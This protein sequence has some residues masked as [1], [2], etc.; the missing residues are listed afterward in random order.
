MGR[1]ENNKRTKLRGKKL[2][3]FLS[4]ERKRK[5]MTQ[6]ELAKL[7]GLSLDTIRS[8]ENKR[9]ASPSFFIIVDISKVL[10]INFN[11]IQKM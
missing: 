4:K 5:N 11:K 7:T 10:N 3:D 8:I 1:K 6:D 2:A 9:V